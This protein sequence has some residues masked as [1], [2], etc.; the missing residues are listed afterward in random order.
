MVEL[1]LL[2]SI[3]EYGL[4]EIGAGLGLALRRPVGE[5]WLCILGVGKL[6]ALHHLALQP[7]GEHDRRRTPLGRHTERKNRKIAHL[8]RTGG[9]DGERLVVP[10][11]SA[12]HCGSVVTLLRIDVSETGTSTVDVH[13][14]RRELRSSK[15]GY[16]LLHQGEPGAGRRRHAELSGGSRAEHHV[17]ARR[18]ALR[19][20]ESAAKH[21][22]PL[23]R[24][25][26]NLACRSDGIAEIEVATGIQRTHHDSFVSF[27][28]LNH[29]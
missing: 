1:L 11:A 26:R 7:V 23:C 12:L 20:H 18:L 9:S 4:H 10:V 22:K 14:N 6:H 16:A 28:E 21:R 17:H 15:V 19:L 25:M 24:P 13:D 29:F 5:I 2:S 3:K 27:Y 8:L